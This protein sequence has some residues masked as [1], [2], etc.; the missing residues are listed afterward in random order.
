MI[1]TAFLLVMLLMSNITTQFRSLAASVDA[2]VVHSFPVNLIFL[3]KD[4]VLR[5]CWSLINIVRC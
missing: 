3:L 2:E 1:W 5:F 4:H